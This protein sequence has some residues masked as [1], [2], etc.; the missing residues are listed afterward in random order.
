MV[1]CGS[2]PWLVLAAEF[3]AAPRRGA[4]TTTRR[5]YA[6]NC[7]AR[8]QEEH[9]AVIGILA[10]GQREIRAALKALGTDAVPAILGAL[11]RSYLDIL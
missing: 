1:P 2:D 8:T 4:P 10:S 6:A 7:A 9:Q 11:D 5:R 3:A